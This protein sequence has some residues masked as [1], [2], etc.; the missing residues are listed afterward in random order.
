MWPLTVSATRNPI[1]LARISA[2]TQAEMVRENDIKTEERKKERIEERNKD[3]KE[4]KEINER[5][6]SRKNNE[7]KHEKM[8]KWM[9]G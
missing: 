5:M 2:I 8:Q 6:K 3:T 1:S 9:D 4:R 7:R